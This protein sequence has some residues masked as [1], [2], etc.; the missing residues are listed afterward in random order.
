MKQ[1]AFCAKGYQ[2]GG[3]RKLLRGHY[4]PTKQSKKQPNLQWA[5]IPGVPGRLKLCVKCLGAL[6][7]STKK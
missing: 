5:K 6:K 4:N 2:M 1:C 7:K 3:T